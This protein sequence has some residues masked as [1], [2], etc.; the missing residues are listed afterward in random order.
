MLLLT[1][2]NSVTS[3]TRAIIGSENC[4]NSTTHVIKDSRELCNKYDSCHYWFRE[5]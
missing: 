3:T 5:L 1:H 4:N 2:G